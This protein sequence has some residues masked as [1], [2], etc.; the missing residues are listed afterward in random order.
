MQADIDQFHD[1]LCAAIVAKVPVSF[2]SGT[3]SRAAR[4]ATV[5]S[6][7]RQLSEQNAPSLEMLSVGPVRYLAACKVFSRTGSMAAVLDG[8]SNTFLIGEMLPI[9]DS[10]GWASGT[11]ATLRNTSEM[12]DRYWWES[13]QYGAADAPEQVGSFGSMHSG[14]ANFV[15]ASGAV[16]FITQSIDPVLYQNLANR[17]DGAMMGEQLNQ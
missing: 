14:G 15:M 10:L 4:V 8:S 2:G 5:E 11:R 13:N 9:Q 3:F 6:L 16:I 1:E 12:V 17:A 7:R